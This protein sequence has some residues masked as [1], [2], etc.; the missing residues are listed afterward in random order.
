MRAE[1]HA[2]V[3]F[4][5]LIPSADGS[6]GV[7]ADIAA[8]LRDA[9]ERRFG[10]LEGTLH[11]LERAVESGIALGGVSLLRLQSRLRELRARIGRRRVEDALPGAIDSELDRLFAQI[12]AHGKDD[13]IEA[14]GRFVFTVDVTF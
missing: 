10:A 1:R 11:Q 5:S 8:R 12:R 3:P 13:S 2:D 4:E 6:I 9:L 14:Y 7:R